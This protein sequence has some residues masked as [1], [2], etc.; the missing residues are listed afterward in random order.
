MIS[1]GLLETVLRLYQDVQP[2]DETDRV[3]HDTAVLLSNLTNPLNLSLLTSHFLTAAAIWA[4]P[5]GPQTGLRVVHTV[6]SAAI[7][8]QQN[9][10]E[11]ARTRGPPRGGGLGAEA[12]AKA[13]AKGADERSER[14]RHL[15]V[16][17][18]LLVGLEGDGRQSMSRGLRGQLEHAVVMAA[19]L[20]LGKDAQGGQMV[21][22]AI[23]LALS[24]VFPLLPSGLKSTLDCDA[25]LPLAITTLTGTE[26]LGSGEILQDIEADSRLVNNQ[27]HWAWAT[28]SSARLQGLQSRPLVAAA[29]SLATIAAFAVEHARDPRVVF[30]A[31]DVL[32]SS[33]TTFSARWSGSPKLS[34]FDTSLEASFLTPETLERT[35]P[36][37]WQFLRKS[38]YSSTLVLQAVLSR[39][40]LD[41]RMR[42]DSVASAVAVKSLRILRNLQF[43]SSRQHAK[44][45]QVYTFVYF[46]SIDILARYPAVAASFLRGILP[47]APEHPSHPVQATSDLFYLDLA[48]HFP[49]V[50]SSEECDALVVQPAMRYIMRAD[51]SAPAGPLSPRTVELFEAAHS[52]VLSVLS[53]P[54][55]APLTVGLAPVYAE[56]L[57]ASFPSR[58]SQR[59]FRFAFQTMM[60]ILSPP[61]P[62]SATHPVLAETLLEMVRM[63]ASTASTA[64]LPPNAEETAK[65]L[66]SVPAAAVSEQSALVLTMIDALPFLAL[67]ILEEWMTVAA[68]AIW[69]IADAAMREAAKQRFWDVLVSGEMDVERAAIGVAWWGTNGG[70]ELVLHGRRQPPSGLPVMSGAIPREEAAS[71]L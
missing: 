4:H 40:L 63:R 65:A 56:A 68:E 67:P 29:G 9:E 17:T 37:L 50:L 36:L 53:S 11:N 55:N 31:Q 42:P 34:G 38:L 33:T 18:G 12:W 57:F 2:P 66:P 60:Q 71:R 26:G 48:E 49:V 7:V 6:S 54:H 16:L 62:V 46:T 25:L 35:W 28:P 64:P 23:T 58:I 15:L 27:L 14:W 32:L 45:F 22:Y 20:A 13:V 39:G 41:P 70:G 1:N 10:L 61:F 19:N 52:A 47:H 30:A 44:S 51:A 21:T 43:I 8:V 5:D 69:D 24:Y 3:Y 59:Q